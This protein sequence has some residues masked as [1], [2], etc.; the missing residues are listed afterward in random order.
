M[1]GQGFGR[2]HRPAAAGSKRPALLGAAAWPYLLRRTRGEFRRQAQSRDWEPDGLLLVSRRAPSVICHNSYVICVCLVV[3]FCAHWAQCSFGCSLN[4]LYAWGIAPAAHAAAHGS[5]NACVHAST[6][7]IHAAF[8]AAACGAQ[9]VVARRM[10]VWQAGVCTDNRICACARTQLHMQ[11]HTHALTH[12]HAHT[13]KYAHVPICYVHTHVHRQRHIP[14][15]AMVASC[16]QTP[17]REGL[18]T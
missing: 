13:R 1:A 15:Y 14:A 2:S 18:T 4:D 17:C 7:G 12:T 3:P 16:T 11:V 8:T 9:L 5:S 6:C 10:T